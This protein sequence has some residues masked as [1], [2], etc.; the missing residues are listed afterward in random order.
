MPVLRNT[1]D[2]LEDR[3]TVS[4]YIS[5]SVPGFLREFDVP[6]NAKEQNLFGRGRIYVKLA[7]RYSAKRHFDK[8]QFERMNDPYFPR[9]KVRW[10]S[11]L[12]KQFVGCA[13]F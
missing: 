13:S 10:S 11:D 1:S 6:W 2:A 12:Q 4:R 5:T 9:F 3:L 7:A 8:V